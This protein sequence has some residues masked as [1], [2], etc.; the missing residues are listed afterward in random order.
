[1]TLNNA[2][3]GVGT[4]NGKGSRSVRSLGYAINAYSREGAVAAPF[5]G[6]NAVERPSRQQK[7]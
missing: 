3:G 4:T 7:R 1:M 2:E 5:E 6:G